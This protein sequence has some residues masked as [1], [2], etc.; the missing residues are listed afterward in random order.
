[1]PTT[2]SRDFV[3]LVKQAWLLASLEQ[4]ATRLRSGHLLW[5]LLADETL[6]LRAQNASG[7]LAGSIG[8]AERDRLASTAAAERPSDRQLQRREFIHDHVP[9]HDGVDISVPMNQAVP[10]DENLAP[11]HLVPATHDRR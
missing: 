3:E 5:A 6:A 9:D 2:P 1:M 11:R 7:D 10:K 4:G 8:P